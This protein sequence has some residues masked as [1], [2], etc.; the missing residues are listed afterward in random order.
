V[1]G[2][3]AERSIAPVLKTGGPARAPGVRIPPHPPL[4]A[5]NSL[6]YIVFI[7]VYRF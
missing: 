4:K 7:Q 5:T 2:W 6:I 1:A 3:V